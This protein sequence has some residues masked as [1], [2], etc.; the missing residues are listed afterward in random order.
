MTHDISTPLFDI[1]D[2]FCIVYKGEPHGGAQLRERV[3]ATVATLRRLGLKRGGRVALCGPKSVDL[4]VLMLATWAAGAVA[5]PLFSGLKTKQVRHILTDSDPALVFAGARDFELVKSAHEGQTWP[6]EDIDAIDTVA[7]GFA[8]DAEQTA[9]PDTTPAAT[10]PRQPAP[11]ITTEGEPALIVYTSGSTGQPKGVVFSRGNL[12]LGA[13]SVARLMRLASDDRVLCLLP[14]SFDAGLNQLLSTLI[15]G[16]TAVLLDFLHA[17]QVEE[18]CATQ[19]ITSMIA[20]PGLWSRIGAAKWSDRARLHVRRIGNTGGHLQTELLKRL[21]GIFFNADVFLMYGFTEAFRAT[22]LDPASVAAKPHSVGRPIPYASVAVV[23]EAGRLCGPH[24]IGELVQFGPLVT[25]GYRNLP[26]ENAVKFRPLP[27]GLIDAL[28]GPEGRRYAFDPAHANSA[29]W[30]GDL[31]SIDED[32][33][34]VYRGR[35]DD[36]IKVNGFR[37]CAGDVEDACVDAGLALAVAI[38]IT[39]GDEESIVV[40]GKRGDAAVQ[41]AGVRDRLR[42]SLPAY[43]VPKQILFLDDFPLTANG[44]FDRHALRTLALQQAE[45]VAP[46]Q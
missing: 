1:D 33:D 36:L 10:T 17:S 26:E 19:R 21:K 12:V 18:C 35:K 3:E 6:L 38:G 39:E 40:F 11:A 20:V 46:A 5:V 45:R 28:M 16:A 9:V 8:R 2:S 25:L 30:S 22:Y 7:A 31:V 29:A 4:C 23:S 13:K 14:F 32:G 37:I 27:A 43:M 44:K 41:E 42:A 24:E 34:I 15:A